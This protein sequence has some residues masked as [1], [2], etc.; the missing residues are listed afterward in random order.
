VSDPFRP[1]GTV[2][3]RAGRELPVR[4]GH[5]WLYRGSLAD[6]LPPTPGPVLVEGADG[7]RL[8]V[9]LVGASGGSLAL[10]MV[11]RGCEAWS[12]AT[13]RVRLREAAAVRER[14]GIDSDA[15]RLVHA[16]GDDLPAL[17]I[18]RYGPVAVV[19]PY[20]PA[21]EPY[22]GEVTAMLTEE[23]GCATV[24]MRRGYGGDR[25]ASALAGALPAE[26]VIVREEAAR[27]PVD[28]AAGQKTGFFLDQR[29]TRWRVA[30]LSTGCTLLNL[31]S[32]S[33]GFAVAALVRGARRAVNVDASRPALELARRA[34]R[35]NGLPADDA[36]FLAGDAFAVAR[37]LAAGGAAF[38]VVVVDPPAFVRRR[39]ELAAGLRGYKEINLQAIRLVAPGGLLVSCSCSA[40]LDEDG[41]GGVL[42]AAAVDAGRSV[43]V[44]ERRGAAPDHPTPLA[45]L[46]MR[47]LKAWLC[48][49]R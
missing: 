49:V 21:W 12:A 10:R 43:R 40:L 11:A 37:E 41:F 30:A 5:P 15:V 28:V 35:L 26:P 22:L 46:E 2:R 44:L 9:A 4:R 14:L 25:R 18:D 13:L 31:F 38:E 16:E 39:S 20:E 17:V 32:Y 33:G 19:E 42:L 7:S 24:V 45:C 27:F 6:R 1:V 29:D 47:H 8:G 23:L 34:Y 48:R 3:L 36:S